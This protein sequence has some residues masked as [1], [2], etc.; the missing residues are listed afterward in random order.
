MLF[1]FSTWIN[2]INRIAGAS[3]RGL[4]TTRVR[5]QLGHAAHVIR[6]PDVFTAPWAVFKLTTSL[7]TSPVLLTRWMRTPQSMQPAP[8]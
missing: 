2:R 1:C 5:I 6:F 8:S 4:N 7:N 3:T